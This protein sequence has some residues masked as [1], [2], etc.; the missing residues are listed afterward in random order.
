MVLNVIVKI[1]K[2]ERIGKGCDNRWT[3]FFNNNNK[4]EVQSIKF[5]IVKKVNK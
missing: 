3:F 5:V 2:L 4:E 1:S